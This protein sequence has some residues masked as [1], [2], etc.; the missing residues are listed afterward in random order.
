MADDQEFPRDV[1]EAVRREMCAS[2]HGGGVC[3]APPCDCARDILRTLAALGYRRVGPDEVVV[4]R[5]EMQSEAEVERDEFF[6]RLGRITSELGLPMDCTAS[7]I[8]EAIDERVDDEREA[9]ASVT[10]R[11]EV[12]AGAEAWTPLEAWE[13]ALLAMDEAFRDAIRNRAAAPDPQREGGA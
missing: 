10:V 3:E 13:E 7:R 5:A 4:N 6:N 9:C 12:P 8:I 2:C 1:V 11:V